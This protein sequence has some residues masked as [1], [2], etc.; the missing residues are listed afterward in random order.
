MLDPRAYVLEL[1]WV[2]VVR[3]VGIAYRD[4]YLPDAPQPFR[5]QRLVTTVER[6]VA[7][8]E[9][10]RRPFG[11]EDRP[12]ALGCLLGPE[13]RVA[14]RRNPQIESVRRHE[15]PVGVDETAFGDAVDPHREG[16]A[17]LHERRTRLGRGTD[18]IRNRET[19]RPHHL[20]AQPTHAPRMLDPVSL[21]KA[22]ILVDLAAHIVGVEVD[23]VEP[24][25]KHARKRRLAGAGQAHD[26]DLVVH[27]TKSL[28]P[29]VAILCPPDAARH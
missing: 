9:Q 1:K 25:R 11:I 16:W 20:I 28:T 3:S 26:E 13:I 29:A 8:D 7:P 14:V 12:D 4:A 23:G 10:R 2:F 19:S 18:E 24:R 15:H 21:G 22:E 17:A 27:G 6:L 5:D